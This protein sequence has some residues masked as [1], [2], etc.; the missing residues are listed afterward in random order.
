MD[1]AG[2]TNAF[3]EIGASYNLTFENVQGLTSKQFNDVQ[4]YANG[5]IG[6]VLADRAAQ[7]A[8]AQQAA[9]QQAAEQAAAANAGSSI[10]SAA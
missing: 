4:S 10:D 5:T 2:R 3:G 8:A 7:Q 1:V 9:A 6:Q